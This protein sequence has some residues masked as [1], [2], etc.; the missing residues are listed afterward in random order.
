MN[1]KEK[2]NAWLAFADEKTKQE[3]ISVSGDEKELEDRFYKDLAFGTG[4]L[5]GVMGAGSNRMNVYTVGR[6]TL[7]LA[8]YLK[9]SFPAGASVAIAYDTRNNSSAFSLAAARILAANGI[10]VYR[11]K[12]CVPVPVLSFTVRCLG[13]SAGIMITA[14]HNPKEYNGYKVYDETGCQ[15]CT[16]AAAALLSYIEKEEY[17]AVSKLLSGAPDDRITE[18][19]DEI[20]ADYYKAVGS[21]SLYTEPSDLKIVYTPLHG[22]GNV[23]VRHMLGGFDVHVVKEQELPDGNFSTVRSPNPEE[24][25]ALN[26]AIE[27]AKEIG[28]DLVLGTD[29]DCDRVGIAVRDTNGEYVLFTGNQTGALLVQFVLT[30]KKDSLSEKSTLVK[31]IVTSELGA[32][33]ARKFGLH[34]DET[35][36]GFKYIGDKINQYEKD[37]SREFVIGYEESYGYLVGTYAR[38]KDGVVSSM[39]ICQMAAWYKAQGKTLIDGLNDIYAEYGYFLDALDPFVLK[40]KD[41]AEK[42]QTLMDLFR[43][44]GLHI[45]E[46]ADRVIDY[47]K[48]VDDL[49][50]ENVLK[51][52]WADGSWVAVRPSGTEPKIKIYYSVREENRKQAH[53]RL[54][55]IRTKVKQII[56]G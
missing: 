27:Y 40:G 24:K 23:P 46:G 14:S 39:L 12:Y 56:E 2:Y 18:I 45:F 11:Y 1:I 28:A 43:R 25:D 32:N 47:S 44:D 9:D 29:P 35:L 36:T 20:L 19:G 49:P 4:G 3:L 41:G 10:R 51:F 21:Q 22:T 37:G 26:I 33:I 54:E 8:N 31:T 30:M 5:R 53:K 7:G 42:I 50:I 38:D 48:G 17:S 55:K 52:V 6:A 16:E 15:I 34:V 13:C